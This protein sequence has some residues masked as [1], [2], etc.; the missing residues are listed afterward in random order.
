MG[1][2]SY[3]D[4]LAQDDVRLKGTRVGIETVLRASISFGQSD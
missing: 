3:F 1:L 2:E 4:F